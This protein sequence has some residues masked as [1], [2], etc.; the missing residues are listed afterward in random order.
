MLL[1][2]L[3]QQHHLLIVLIVLALRKLDLQIAVIQSVTI[4][5]RHDLLNKVFLLHV[6]S[7]EIHGD[8]QRF[9]PAV[10]PPSQELACFLQHIVVQLADAAL[11]FQNRNKRTGGNQL[12]LVQPADKSLRSADGTIPKSHLRLIENHKFP[13]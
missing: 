8:A 7:G 4:N 12:S 11:L 9:F 13:R 5:H 1:Q 10:N 3:H 6:P 2:A